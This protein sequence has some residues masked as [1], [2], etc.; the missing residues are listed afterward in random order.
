MLLS[1]PVK[2]DNYF[3]HKR[4]PFFFPNVMVEL[5]GF[6]APSTNIFSLD[7]SQYS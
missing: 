4:V 1:A 7:F 5:Q 6:M 2:I 3:Y